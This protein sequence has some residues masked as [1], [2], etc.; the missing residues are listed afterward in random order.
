M[1]RTGRNIAAVVVGIA[2]IA[3][4]WMLLGRPES[5]QGPSPVPATSTAQSGPATPSPGA[6]DGGGELGGMDAGAAP[7]TDA[8]R[9]ASAERATAA[10]TV[11]VDHSLDTTAWHD[12][13]RP[14]V[15]ADAWPQLAL[16]DPQRVTPRKVTG[17]PRELTATHTAAEYAVPTDAG[18]LRVTVMQ[19]EDGTWLVTNIDK[20]L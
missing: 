14:Q 5:P 15:T 8:D 2:V 13:L 6:S 18:A 11:W 16:P 19:Q 3:A 10:A 9:Q 17:E 20:A 1:S 4:L 12:Q 7:A